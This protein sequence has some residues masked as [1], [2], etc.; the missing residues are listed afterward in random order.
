MGEAERR[1]KAVKD[2]HEVE[3]EFM[4]NGDEEQNDNL[5]SIYTTLFYKSLAKQAGKYKEKQ[6]FTPFVSA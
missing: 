3:K 4:N 1:D 6:E 2:L 5:R